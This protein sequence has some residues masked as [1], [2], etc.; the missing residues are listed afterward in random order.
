MPWLFTFPRHPRRAAPAHISMP[1][2]VRGFSVM[3]LCRD[4]RVVPTHPAPFSGARYASH[5]CRKTLRRPSH[6][7]RSG[8]RP[9]VRWLHRMRG[10]NP[11]HLVL[12]PPAG[13]GQARR[14]CGRRQGAGVASACHPYGLETLAARWRGRQTGQRDSGPTQDRGRSGQ[15]RRRRPRGA[16]FGR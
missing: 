15:R 11:R 16:A 12:W 5:H 8:W 13:A 4:S 9:Q 10:I 7:W 1:G 3:L 2:A 6:R 14:L